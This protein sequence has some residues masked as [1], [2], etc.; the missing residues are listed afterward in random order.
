MCLKWWVIC[1]L[2]S[3]NTTRTLSPEIHLMYELSECDLAP[4]GR[5]EDTFLT[6]YLGDELLLGSGSIVT[7]EFRRPLHTVTIHS[8]IWKGETDK[9]QIPKCDY[10]ALWVGEGK[11]LSVCSTHV[12]C[13]RPASSLCFA[14]WHTLMLCFRLELFL[15]V[16]WE[17][18]Q[19]MN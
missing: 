15:W 13:S 14:W 2:W 1:H 9:C 7:A 10:G 6:G 17:G 12:C 3:M 18:L 5:M 4:V 16:G 8:G 11:F 19:Y